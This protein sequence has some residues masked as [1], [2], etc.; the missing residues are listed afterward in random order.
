[1]K[2]PLEYMRVIYRGGTATPRIEPGQCVVC[3]AELRWEICLSEGRAAYVYRTER[4]EVRLDASQGGAGGEVRV[5][6]C[7]HESYGMELRIYAPE[8]QTLWVNGETV[9][10]RRSGRMIL[11]RRER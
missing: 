10:F 8:A 4:G 1:M 6:T 3:P 11:Y 5:N 7:G 9:S 2:T